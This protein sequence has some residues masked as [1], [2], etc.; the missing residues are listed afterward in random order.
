[1]ISFLK[2]TLFVLFPAQVFWITTTLNLL[3]DS[4]ISNFAFGQW[5]LIISVIIGAILISLIVLVMDRLK[6]LKI[7]SF[8]FFIGILF[9]FFQLGIGLEDRSYYAELMF[10]GLIFYPLFDKVF[11]KL[12]SFFV[13]VSFMY[14]VLNSYNLTRLSI[15]NSLGDKPL[16]EKQLIEF[17]EEK[18][19]PNIYHFLIDEASYVEF[20][21]LKKQNL[22]SSFSE[23]DNFTNM[24]TNYSFSMGSGYSTFTSQYLMN[25]DSVTD[26]F[27]NSFLEGNNFIS[28]L[29]S[30][31]YETFKIGNLPDIIKTNHKIRFEDYNYNAKV[32][33]LKEINNTL[34]FFQVFKKKFIPFFRGSF[35]NQYLYPYVIYSEKYGFDKFIEQELDLPNS[36]RYNLIYL[37]SPH[38]PYLLD[39][40]CNH[41]SLLNYTSYSESYQCSMKMISKFLSRLKEENRF[42]SSIIIIHS[43]HGKN[44]GRSLGDLGDRHHP[45]FLMKN[46]GQK[47]G[48]EINVPGE[49]SDLGITLMNFLG[50]RSS[51]GGYDLYSSHLRKINRK[52]VFFQLNPFGRFKKG[53]HYSLDNEMNS[54]YMGLYELQK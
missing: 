22:I 4:S 12:K 14:L 35:L 51:F 50:V 2:K 23:F 46:R 19:L 54:R 9:V 25:G 29:E 37:T 5:Y 30:L 49:L 26:K 32:F 33:D 24:V 10:V 13:L 43:D 47:L 28:K 41:G 15:F 6:K 42:D 16:Y 44:H 17:T 11:L 21:R 40:N 34:V 20:E 36:G 7:L 27:E 53:F 52:R 39:E 18:S 45:V 8:I 48:R 38:F 3:L 31:G 1:M